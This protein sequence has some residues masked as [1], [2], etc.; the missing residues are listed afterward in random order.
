MSFVSLLDDI[1]DL[2]DRRPVCQIVDDLFS[3]SPNS[4]DG[5]NEYQQQILTIV[6]LLKD[7]SDVTTLERALNDIFQLYIELG[8]RGIVGD[9]HAKNISPVEFVLTIHK[10]RLQGYD[11]YMQSMIV[12]AYCNE[13]VFKWLCYIIPPI[14]RDWFVHLCAICDNVELLVWC[15][16]TFSLSYEICTLHILD[17]CA[18][19]NNHALIQYITRQKPELIEKSKHLIVKKAYEYDS[20]EML[21]VLLSFNVLTIHDI[22]SVRR[23]PFMHSNVK[24]FV[25]LMLQKEVLSCVKLPHHSEQ[26]FYHLWKI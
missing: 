4:Y 6:N 15:K 9:V 8:M 19:N 25:R 20:V 26:V 7:C 22:V 11:F 12:A 16:E 5:L 13:N 3:S 1:N 2:R 24:R 23:L 17:N 18:R 21:Q 10:F 14:K